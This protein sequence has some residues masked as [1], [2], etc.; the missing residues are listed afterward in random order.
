MW[1]PVTLAV[2]LCSQSN[3]VYNESGDCTPP[4]LVD[5]WCPKRFHCADVTTKESAV[6]V[7]VRKMPGG[8]PVDTSAVKTVR[9]I[10]QAHGLDLP[11]VHS[12]LENKCTLAAGLYGDKGRVPLGIIINSSLPKGWKWMDGTPP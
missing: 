7:R 8:L 12:D 2:I 3:I 4:L 11:S 1:A 5:G 10:C 9:S 6:L